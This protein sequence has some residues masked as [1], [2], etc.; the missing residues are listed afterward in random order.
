MNT[1]AFTSAQSYL[2]AQ[3]FCALPISDL[4]DKGH[5]VCV[6]KEETYVAA[7][8]GGHMVRFWNIPF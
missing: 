1:Y 4:I 2:L 6:P 5:I 7:V 8:C 3:Q